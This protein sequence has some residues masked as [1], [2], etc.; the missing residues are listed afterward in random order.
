M[1]LYIPV[2][3]QTLTLAAKTVLCTAVGQPMSL[4][5]FDHTPTVC[6][7]DDC[8]KSNLNYYVIFTLGSSTF[9]LICNC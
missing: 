5:Y 7:T 2:A 9:Q 1:H 4:A 3:A 6:Q 8:V